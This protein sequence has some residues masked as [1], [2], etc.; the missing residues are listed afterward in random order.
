MKIYQLDS[1][2]KRISYNFDTKNVKNIEELVKL[3]AKN[4]K[5]LKIFDK[6]FKSYAIY[7][8]SIPKK[9]CKYK[10]ITIIIDTLNNNIRYFS[11]L[12]N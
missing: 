8:E 12:C 4:K 6:T 10:E 9:I 2:L 7:I 11:S 5:D 1:N 3:V